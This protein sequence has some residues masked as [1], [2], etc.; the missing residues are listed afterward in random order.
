MRVPGFGRSATTYNTFIIIALLDE[1]KNREKND[2]TNMRLKIWTS[3][4]KD[5]P[6]GEYA[7]SGARAG[8]AYGT[9][10]KNDTNALKL[11]PIIFICFR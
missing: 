11:N 1:W 6:Y 4:G 7:I 8:M 3:I 9:A 10:N 2:E 5:K